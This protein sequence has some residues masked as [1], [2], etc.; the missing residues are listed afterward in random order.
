MEDKAR[1]GITDFIYKALKQI[2]IDEDVRLSDR[3]FIADCLA[4]KILSEMLEP[5]TPELLS[6][7]EIEQAA[8]DGAL[9]GLNPS[10]KLEGYEFSICYGV[11]QAQLAKFPKNLWRLRE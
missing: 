11:A 10:G 7:E 9:L 8:I 4:P 3:A 5:V 1:E 2:E 6:D